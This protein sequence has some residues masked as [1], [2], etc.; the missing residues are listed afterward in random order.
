MRSLFFCLVLA[1]A[2]SHEPPAASA[3]APLPATERPAPQVELKLCCEQ[4]LGAAKRD[5]VGTSIEGVPCSKYPLSWNGGA[6]V[7]APCHDVFEKRAT[8]VGECRGQT[9]PQ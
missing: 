4:C 2:C 8:T 5:Q 7:D 9:A 6:G 3:T 1:A